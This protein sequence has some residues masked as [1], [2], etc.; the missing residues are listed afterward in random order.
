MR[1]SQAGLQESAQSSELQS[2]KFNLTLQKNYNS[3]PAILTL[4]TAD[5]AY[6]LY[7]PRR[8]KTPLQKTPRARK[9]IPFRRRRIPRQKTDTKTATA[10]PLPAAPPHTFAR[11]KY[12][13]L[14]ISP[15]Y[16]Y[17]LIS[18]CAIFYN[19][20]IPSSLYN[21]PE[22]CGQDGGGAEKPWKKAYTETRGKVFQHFFRKNLHV[23]KKVPTFASLL[24]NNPAAKSP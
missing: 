5:N 12:T 14:H 13:P 11:H 6:S 19:N 4:L 2:Y 3:E 8:K 20:I 17:V 9:T 1:T 15:L 18:T 16:Y 10:P 7:S 21:S 24:R 22:R 23:L